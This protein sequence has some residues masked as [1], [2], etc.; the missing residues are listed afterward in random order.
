MNPASKRAE[1]YLIQIHASQI[2]LV[3]HF[4]PFYQ[5]AKIP[6][7]EKMNTTLWNN[8]ST[9]EAIVHA[10]FGLGSMILHF[11]AI[12]LCCAIIDYQD[13]K[14]QNEKSSFDV[15]TKG[16]FISKCPYEKSVSSKIPTKIFLEF[17]PE[18]FCS[19]LGASW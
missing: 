3:C 1:H 15:L 9:P 19:F 2:N 16:Q 18:I 13:E 6:F 11:Y 12:F 10:M 8:H 4:F 5:E 17:C 7:K 14:P